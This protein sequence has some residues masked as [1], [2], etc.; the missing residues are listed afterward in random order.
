MVTRLG[1]EESWVFDSMNG[2]F[3]ARLRRMT[4]QTRTSKGD[5]REITVSNMVAVVEAKFSYEALD[6]LYYPS[7]IAIEREV[8]GRLS[9]VIFEVV[10]INPTHY[11]QLGMDVSM[12]TVLRK[13]YLDTINE[14]WGKSQETWID[15]WAIPT[16]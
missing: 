14:S 4:V 11:Q 7:F 9:H 3:E 10:S 12:P 5:G 2:T 15:L 16:W 6:R 1:A 13:E 8:K